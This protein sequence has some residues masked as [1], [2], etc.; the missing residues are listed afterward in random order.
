M[1]YK[2]TADL[3]DNCLFILRISGTD[4]LPR[5]QL[6]SAEISKAFNEISSAEILLHYEKLDY[7]AASLHGQFFKTGADIEL[8]GNICPNEL[9]KFF[10]GSVISLRWEFGEG[11]NVCLRIICK[12]RASRIAQVEVRHM[13]SPLSDSHLM[14]RIISSH[15][16]HPAVEQTEVILDHA[17]LETANEW[18]LLC[19]LAERN[20]F[21]I[22]CGENDRLHAGTPM[23]KGQILPT[24]TL[25]TPG[26]CF[27]LGIH[28]IGL[29]N[30]SLRAITQL[31]PNNPHIV[32][33]KI[34]LPHHTPLKP[35]SLVQILGFGDGNDGRSIITKVIYR[36]ENLEWKSDLEFIR[37]QSL[38]DQR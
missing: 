13:A 14:Q 20:G 19:L 7:G 21:V 5:Y 9:V 15:G 3:A 8:M 11:Q 35:G 2:P 34:F 28:G 23:L 16:L 10:S 27:N 18:E 25:G 6:V 38:A 24:I 1:D 29:P 32:E 17:P 22:E 33:G 36:M 31:L 26:V 12:H 30:R 37:I 4:H